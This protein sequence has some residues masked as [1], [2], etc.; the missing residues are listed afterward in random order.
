MKNAAQNCRRCNARTF[1]FFSPRNLVQ[2]LPL[3]VV[4]ALPLPILSRISFSCLQFQRDDNGRRRYDIVSLIAK[5]RDGLPLDSSEIS[6]LVDAVSRQIIDHVQ[7]GEYAI[8]QFSFVFLTTQCLLPHAVNCVRFCFWR[9]LWPF[10][11]VY[12]PGTAERICAKFTRKT[13]LVPRSDEFEGLKIKGQRSRSPGTRTTFSALSAACVRCVFGK[14]SLASTWNN[15]PEDSTNF[16]S[17][18]LFKR[19]LNSNILVRHCKIYYF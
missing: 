6:H 9:C 1:V 7:I 5:K 16:S 4:H 11:F 13:C 3:S 2:H 17:L 19:C 15:L 10:L 18:A 12:E 8:P 14:T